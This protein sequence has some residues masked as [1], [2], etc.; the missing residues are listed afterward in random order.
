MQHFI[1]M[2]DGTTMMIDAGDNG[3]NIGSIPIPPKVAAEW[4]A[5]YMQ[6]LH[7]PSYLIQRI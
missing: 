2:P 3:K 1:I 7:E 6:A 4:Q 5:T